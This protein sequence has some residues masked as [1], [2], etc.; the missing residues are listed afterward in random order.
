MTQRTRPMIRSATAFLVLLVIFLA[1]LPANARATEYVSEDTIELT[2]TSTG[3]FELNT[4]NSTLFDLKN[5]VPGDTWYGRLHVVNDTNNKMELSIISITSNLEDELLFDLLD[6]QIA[7]DGEVVYDGSYGATPDPITDWMSV[8]RKE[9]MVIDLTVT[10]PS[11]VGNEAQAKKMDS[12]WVFEARYEGKTSTDHSYRYKVEY[13]DEDGNE[14]LP[15]KTGKCERRE[16]VVE[17]APDIEGYTPDAEMKT[18][19]H[20]GGPMKKN[21]ITFIYSKDSAPVSPSDPSEPQSPVTPVDPEPGS[22]IQT[23]ADMTQSNTGNAVWFTI[24]GL[25][26]ICA[27]IILIRVDNAKKALHKQEADSGR[28]E[29]K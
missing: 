18:L 29:K 4:S 22:G 19:V 10:L 24:I 9:P 20:N 14:L 26:F 5:M 16:E 6:L 3:R 12:T 17:Y 2:G 21:V 28:E 23:G 15:N 13:L 27:G 8:S 11:K 7:V 1:L 25:C